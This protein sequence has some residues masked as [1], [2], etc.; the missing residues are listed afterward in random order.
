MEGKQGLGFPRQQQVG[1][2]MNMSCFHNPVN[3]ADR[4]N[5]WQFVLWFKP[6]M[7]IL[8]FILS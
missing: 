2:S 4:R 1:L 8:A 3:S 6:D 5:A 7:F